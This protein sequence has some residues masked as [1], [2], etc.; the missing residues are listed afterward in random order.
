MSKYLVPI[1]LL[2]PFNIL[3]GP[4]RSM[5]TKTTDEA[6]HK[7][8]ISN[9]RSISYNGNMMVISHKDGNESSFNINEVKSITFNSIE[10]SIQSIC[11]R[12]GEEPYSIYDINGVEIQSGITNMEGGID[13]KLNLHGV[14]VVKV[15]DTTKKVIILN[16]SK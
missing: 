15:G 14:F 9:I 8:A 11:Q 2:L 10:T 4:S 7:M 12:K 13:N 1:L 5:T 3:A 6:A 16:G